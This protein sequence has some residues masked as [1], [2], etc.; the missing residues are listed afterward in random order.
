MKFILRRLY[1]DRRRL[2]IVCVL[3]VGYGFFA[4]W[5]DELLPHGV[6]VSVIFGVLVAILSGAVAALFSLLIPPFRYMLEWLSVGHLLPPILAGLFPDTKFAFFIQEELN[7]I[8]GVIIVLFIAFYMGSW[9]DKYLTV[10]RAPI[11]FSGKT[12]IAA[13]RLWD[14][15]YPKPE[16]LHL[17]HNDNLE[18]LEYVNEGEPHMRAVEWVEPGGLLE[19]INIVEKLQPGEYVR[20]RWEAVNGRGMHGTFGT[21]EIGVEDLGKRRRIT[22]SFDAPNPPLRRV[23]MNWIDDT[24]GR[25][26]DDQLRKLEKKVRN[27]EAAG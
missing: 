21:A 4:D 8:S 1:R 6:L 3:A 22:K 16:K 13:E 12:R 27:E 9:L 5:G 10:K 7:V 26:L 25:Q 11:R 20:F 18:N 2:A 15:F 24:H 19:E 17:A 23:V 14:G